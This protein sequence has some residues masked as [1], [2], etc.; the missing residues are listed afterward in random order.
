MAPRYDHKGREGKGDEEGEA[1]GEGAETIAGDTE[2]RKEAGR[3]EQ[4]HVSAHGHVVAVGEIGEVEDAVDEGEAHGAEGDDGSEEDAV[5]DEAHL[6][7]GE[8]PDGHSREDYGQGGVAGS[9]LASNGAG[10]PAQ[11]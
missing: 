7:E 11:G 2:P 1:E 9:P 8:E 3:Q 5:H 4:G 10:E 6:D